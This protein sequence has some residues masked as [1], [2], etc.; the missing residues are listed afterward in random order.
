MANNYLDPNGV[1]YLW[2][3]FKGLIPTKVSQFTNDAG[4]LKE[5]QDISGKL[6]KTGN[7]VD[8]TV[9]FNEATTRTNVVSGEKMGTLIGKISKWFGDMRTV[10]FTGSY[11]D[12]SDTPTIPSK[13]TDLSDGSD[14]T[15]TTIVNSMITQKGYQTAS[16]VNDAIDVKGFQ[17]ASQ[18]NTAITSKGYQ[19]ESQVNALIN[20]A[21]SGMTG[22]DFQVVGELP[23]TGK[24]GTIYLLS[25][26]G[27]N[28]NAYDE[29]IYVGNKFEKI[30]STDVDL[31]GYLKTTD[32]TAITNAQIDTICV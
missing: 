31:S 23:T 6:D 18:V 10:A 12:L 22:V 25:N 26:S 7:A 17:T 4:Y 21:L 5:H 11:K 16:Q 9:T 15:T 2:N 13:V 1:L 30:G 20:S 14:Y 3:K 32:M 8:V 19:T 24:A 29:Y 27:T 28:P